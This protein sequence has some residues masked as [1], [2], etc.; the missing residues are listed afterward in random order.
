MLET[1]ACRLH[2]SLQIFENLVDLRVNVA[3]DELRGDRIEWNL[4]R[5]I[6]GCAHANCLRIRADGRRRSL[7]RDDFACIRH[8]MIRLIACTFVSTRTRRITRARWLRLR[9]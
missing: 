8:L 1:A 3:D 9:T 4:A 6:D 5:Q 7:C 2:D